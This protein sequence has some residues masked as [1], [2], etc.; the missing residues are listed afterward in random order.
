MGIKEAL[1]KNNTL[2]GI[3]KRIKNYREF[4]ADAKDFSDNYEEVAERQGDFRY[5]LMLYIHNLEKGM[6]RENPRPFGK[7][8]VEVM[9]NILKHSSEEE[10]N[11]FEYRLA[12]SILKNWVAFYEQKGWQ[13]E[14]DVLE[15]INNLRDTDVSAGIEMLS[16]P[17]TVN[18]SFDDVVFSRRSVRDFDPEK[19]KQDDIDYAINCFIA[20]PTA[21]NRQMCKVY[22][23]Q[24]SRKKQL[25][26]DT[27][28]GISGF[29]VSNTTLFII[30][31]DVSA[32]E[33]YGERNQ[34]YVNVGLAAMNFANALHARGIGSCFMQWSNNRSDDVMIRKSLGIPKSERIGIVLGAGYYK[35]EVYIPKSV[36]K[37]KE[38]IFNVL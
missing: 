22:Q 1:K 31:Y 7:E 36:R 19:L 33:F 17:E 15:F 34:G 27:I 26:A 9:I 16:R 2:R 6:C 35:A 18:A 5:R 11:L 25:L 30:T 38:L 37:N 29:N 23:V 3:V 4:M 24:N 13:I 21:C 28:L 12:V 32:F 10:K 14:K 20:T 8:K